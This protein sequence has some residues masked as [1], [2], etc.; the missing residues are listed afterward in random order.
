MYDSSVKKYK[1]AEGMSEDEYFV[2]FQMFIAFVRT[3]NIYNSKTEHCTFM[4][5]LT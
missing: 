1:T 5:E 2:K 3:K 4:T